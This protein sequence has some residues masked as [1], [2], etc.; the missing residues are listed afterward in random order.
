MFYLQSINS[1]ESLGMFFS[2]AILG[3]KLRKYAATVVVWRFRVTVNDCIG[4]QLMQIQFKKNRE[5]VV[6]GV[7]DERN[8]AQG[9]GT[10]LQILRQIYTIL[11]LG[12]FLFLKILIQ[13][14]EPK[15]GLQP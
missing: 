13:R 1:P 5:D 10:K 15:I 14:N 11:S 2:F 8:Q 3:R 12:H 4:S 7:F 6:E 9:F